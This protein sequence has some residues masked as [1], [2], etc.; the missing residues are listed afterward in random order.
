MKVFEFMKNNE[1]DYPDDMEKIL[2]YLN[3]VGRVNPCVSSKTIEKLYK[4]FSGQW[5]ATWLL[6]DDKTLEDFAKWLS[7]KEVK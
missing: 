2:N 7:E 1:F 6:L 3:E 5:E 4:E